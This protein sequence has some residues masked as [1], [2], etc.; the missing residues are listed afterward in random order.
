MIPN[1]EILNTGI[2]LLDNVF[3][4]TC[5]RYLT[6]LAGFTGD[7]RDKLGNTF[8]HQKKES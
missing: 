1:I 8:L 2:C 3:L 7:E 5:G 4:K 6:P